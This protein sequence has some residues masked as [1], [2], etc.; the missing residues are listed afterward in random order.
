MPTEPAAPVTDLAVNT[1]AAGN[2]AAAIQSLDE[3]VTAELASQLDSSALAPAYIT[4][5]E[6]VPSLYRQPKERQRVGAHNVPGKGAQ[7]HGVALQLEA[8]H[9][10]AG[11]GA[12]A[13]GAQQKIA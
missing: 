10:E 2:N 4:K 8:S 1:A 11:H 5:L 9:R 3:R 6:A 7:G 13:V 12:L